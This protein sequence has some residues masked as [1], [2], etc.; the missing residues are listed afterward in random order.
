M[1]IP[2]AFLFRNAHCTLLI[3]IQLIVY[4]CIFRIWFCL[5]NFHLRIESLF[6]I[7]SMNRCECCRWNDTPD[8]AV[9]WNRSIQN[10]NHLYI[11]V[12]CRKFFETL[13]IPLRIWICDKQKMCTSH[14]RNARQTDIVADAKCAYINFTPRARARS[15]ASIPNEIRVI[16]K[17]NWCQWVPWK[18]KHCSSD[19]WYETEPIDGYTRSNQTKWICFVTH[20]FFFDSPHFAKPNASY[21]CIGKKT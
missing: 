1:L 11:S 20:F 18:C 12:G 6:W 5:V 9:W 21:L 7:L 17:F 3:A 10:Q 14:I 19:W 15:F 4:R 2:C 13:H 8:G 16:L